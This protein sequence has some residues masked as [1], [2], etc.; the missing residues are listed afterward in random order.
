M[1][2]ECAAIASNSGLWRMLN[3]SLGVPSAIIPDAGSIMWKNNL[4]YKHVVP[5]NMYLCI[6]E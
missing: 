3:G 6:T 4:S 2:G 5:N 1:G